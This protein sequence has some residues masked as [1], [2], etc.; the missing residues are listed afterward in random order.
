MVMP[1]DNVQMEIELIQPIALE[2]GLRFAI[3]E[4][5]RTVGAGVVTKITSR[6]RSEGGGAGAAADTKIEKFTVIRSPFID[7]DSPGALRDADAQASDRRAGAE[8]R[9][10]STGTHAPESAGVAWR[11]PARI[12]I[13]LAGKVVFCRGYEVGQVIDCSIFA[14][15]AKVDV[16]GTTKG[17]GFAGVVK[18]H[19]FS[20]GPKTHG[21]SDRHRAPGSIGSSATPGRVFKNMKMAGRMGNERHTVQ[22]LEVVSVDPEKNL[23]LVRGAV[24]GVKDGLLIVRTSVK[25]RQAKR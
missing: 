5:G 10:R 12:E 8:P 19:G 15:G 13:K 22:G 3:R 18:R 20:G 6:H 7:K 14:P 11:R 16:T 17:K 21:Q 4:G 9:R 23:V 25:S 24:P 1:G 2:E